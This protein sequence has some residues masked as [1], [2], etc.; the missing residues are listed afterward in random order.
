MTLAQLAEHFDVHP[1][2]I[3]VWKPCFRKE[4]PMFSVPA[5]AA[6][7]RVDKWG[8][9]VKFADVRSPDASIGP[10][11]VRQATFRIFAFEPRSA[12]AV[13]GGVGLLPW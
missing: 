7:R 6:G 2:Q 4:L 3:T 11:F 8:K 9:V 5:A 10:A 13:I 1:N 12:T